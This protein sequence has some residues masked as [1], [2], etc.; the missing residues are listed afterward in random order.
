M[1]HMLLVVALAMAAGPAAALSLPDWLTG[2][3]EAQEPAGP[4]RPVVSV[5]VED[6]SADE[7]SAAGGPYP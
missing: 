3:A 2:G 5:I 1:R 4:P 6:R 7:R